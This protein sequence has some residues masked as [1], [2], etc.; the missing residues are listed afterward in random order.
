MA[1]QEGQAGVRTAMGQ[2]MANLDKIIAQEDARLAGARADID[3]AEAKGAQQ[4]MLDAE[5][6]SQAATA[7]GFAGLQKMGEKAQSFISLYP[8]TGSKAAPTSYLTNTPQ[9]QVSSRTQAPL[10][11]Q[12]NPFAIT[13]QPA[14]LAATYGPMANYTPMAPYGQQDF[15]FGN[16]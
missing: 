14:P 8:E 3:L 7:A 2:E 13:S 5:K 16:P 4:A 6:A 15:L 12:I 1:Q 9:G 11:T 10:F